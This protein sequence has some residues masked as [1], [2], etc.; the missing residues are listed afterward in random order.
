LASK[1][2]I[3]MIVIA[4][5]LLFTLLAIVYLINR[6]I[7]DTLSN[8]ELQLAYQ[9]VIYLYVVTGLAAASIILV[10]L[11]DIPYLSRKDEKPA[12]KLLSFAS[13]LERREKPTIIPDIYKNL[14]P[15]APPLPQESNSTAE[16][17]SQPFTSIPAE[18]EPSGI[19]CRY[20]GFENDSD[21]VFCQKCGKSMIRRNKQKPTT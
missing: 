2:R 14:T 4:D 12:K 13:I 21:A 10:S 18:K 8:Y 11:M 20:C 5:V 3:V 1:L 7:I 15:D 17:V 19:Y 6:L 9:Y 16:T